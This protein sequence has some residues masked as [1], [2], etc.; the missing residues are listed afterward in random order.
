MLRTVAFSDEPIRLWVHACH[1]MH[2]PKGYV[3]MLYKSPIYKGPKN[4][5]FGSGVKTTPRRDTRSVHLV[6][7]T[8]NSAFDARAGAIHASYLKRYS[9]APPSGRSTCSCRMRRSGPEPERPAWSGIGGGMTALTDFAY[10]G[11]KSGT[12]RAEAPMMQGTPTTS[13]LKRRSTRRVLAPKC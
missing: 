10:P 2:A 6:P 11:L 9:T 5:L 3:Q 7:W 1:Y 12:A 4:C 13:T 8:H